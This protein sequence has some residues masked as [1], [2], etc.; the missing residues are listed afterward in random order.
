MGVGGSV[1][2]GTTTCRPG[3]ASTADAR[4]SSRTSYHAARKPTLRVGGNIVE[5]QEAEPRLPSGEE[6]GT[7]TQISATQPWENEPEDPPPENQDSPTQEGPP[8]SQGQAG[9]F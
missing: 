8:P 4:G 3:I 7:E 6:S 5:L 9:Q 1:R 2:G